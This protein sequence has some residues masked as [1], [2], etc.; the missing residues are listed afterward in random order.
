ML[1]RLV[2]FFTLLISTVYAN[3]SSQERNVHLS[4]NAYSVYDPLSEEEILHQNSDFSINVDDVNNILTS[5]L[6][7]KASKS[8]KLDINQLV[9][10]DESILKK[11]DHS[12]KRP[13]LFLP[14]DKLTVSDLILSSFFLFSID[15]TEI[16]NHFIDKH[17]S[18]LKQSLLQEELGISCDQEVNCFISTLSGKEFTHILGKTF[19]LMSTTFDEKDILQTKLIVNG[20]EYP[21]QW[22]Q[23]KSE[24]TIL[25]LYENRPSLLGLGITSVK[26]SKNNYRTVVATIQLDNI[27]TINEM[28]VL[29]HLLAQG[30]NEFETIQLFKAGD[31]IGSLPILGGIHEHI[32]ILAPQDIYVTL[33]K[34]DLKES[35]EKKL[36]TF[37]EREDRIK[38]PIEAGEQL[39]NF[40]ISYQ[41]DILRT[42][43]LVAEDK[44]QETNF[45]VLIKK[46]FHHLLDK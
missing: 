44:V 12:R 42:V 32:N 10:I 30:V 28:N 34:I 36:E 27:K 43:P 9:T 2:L 5:Y 16:L 11:S 37:I 24:T 22:K 21:N 3:P 39:A 4:A 38:A 7:L 1:F 20:K 29:T 45:L 25:L 46:T 23:S 15:A 19:H 35:H 13:V 40:L 18:D 26:N 6:I 31:L 33:R 8:N 41:G 17:H 14:G